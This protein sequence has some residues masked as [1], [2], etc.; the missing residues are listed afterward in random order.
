MCGGFTHGPNAALPQQVG[1][2]GGGLFPN[3]D[4]ITQRSAPRTLAEEHDHQLILGRVDI[5]D[6]TLFLRH[7]DTPVLQYMK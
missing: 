2:R 1:V 4:I 5:P 7:D 3:V 6:V